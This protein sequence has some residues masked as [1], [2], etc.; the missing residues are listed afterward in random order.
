MNTII[1]IYSK[2]GDVKFSTSINIGAKAKFTLMQEDYIILPFSS[3]TPIDFKL[4]D[5]VDLNEF[6]NGKF[7]GILAKRYEITENQKPTYNSDTGG[8]D[9][10]LKL[11]AYYW[12]WK[13]KIFKYTPEHAASEASWSLT[14]ALDV[15]LGV[16]L[17]NLKA[18]GYTY[19]GEDFT[20]SIDDTVENKAV[21]M[22][23]DNMNLLD[24]LFSMASEENWNCDCWISDN[25][26]HFGRNEYG[27]SVEIRRGVEAESI[28]RSD[29]DGTYATRIY[30]FGST[31]NIPSNYRQ[32][33][34]QAVVNGV[35]QKRLM[36]PA[37]TP[38]IDAYEGMTQEEAIE[39]VVVYDDIY[40]RRVG[41]LS[42]VHTRSEDVENDDGTKE[43]V[44]YYR[45]VDTGLDF[46]EDYILEGEELKITFQ[47]GKLNGLEFGVI[48]NPN[49]KD[50]TRGEQ[51]W[52]IVRNEDYGR[53]LPDDIMKPEDGD[54]YILSGFN[55]QLVSDQYIPAAE[56]ELKERA[57]KDAERAKKDDGT[58]EVKLK[59][60]WVMEDPILRTFEFG[61]KISLIDDT[62]FVN[63]RESRVLGW[64]LNL[65]IP[66]DSPIYTIG[67]S[68][69]YSRITDIED[70]LDALTYK[71]A[72]YTGSGGAG[73]YLIKLN[74]S[75]AP[76][77]SNAFS[78]K[79]S[80]EEFLSK[81]N[82][83]HAKGKITFDSGAEFGEYSEGALGSG[84]A[85]LIDEEGRSYQEV[86]YLTVRRKATYTTIDVQ[87]LKHIGGELILSPAAMTIKSVE[88]T[89]NGY[90]CYFETEDADGKKIYNEF[91]VG[92]QGRCQTF[93][94]E[95]QG[96]QRAGNRYW[97]RLVVETGDDFVVFSKSDADENSDAPIA[98]D[99]VAQLGNR[100]DTERQNA[101][102]YSAYGQ[103]APS[104]K[105]YQGIDSYSL[106]DK[107]IKEE[108]YD[109]S[110]G[111]YKEVTYGDAYFGD[112]EGN[113]YVKYDTAKGV[114]IKGKVQIE[115]GSTGASNLQDLGGYISENVKVGAENL[116]LNTGFTGSYETENLK[117]EDNLESDT[118]LYSKNLE[119]WTGKATVVEDTESVSGYS[120]K[121][122]YLSQDI[123]L[124][125]GEKYVIS[126]KAKN[127]AVKISCGDFE[128][129]QA[130]DGEYKV[131]SNTFT[132]SGEQKFYISGTASVCEIKLERGTIATDWCPSRL[133]KNPVADNFKKYWYLMD[134][135]KGTTEI[136]GGLILTS[137]IRLG[138]WQDGKLQKVNACI[139][140]IYNDDDDVAF[141]AGGDLDRA[142]YTTML[143]KNNPTY[144]PTEEELKNI[145]NCVITHGGRAILN[146]V[147]LR[148]YVYAL[149]G[150]FNGTIYAEGGEFGGY[151]KTS[152]KELSESDAT[153]GSFQVKTSDTETQEIAGHRLASDLN[154]YITSRFGLN[155]IVLP[156]DEEYIGSHVFICNAN[157]PPFHDVV[158]L[159]STTFIW[160]GMYSFGFNGGYQ[161]A[162]EDTNGVYMKPLLGG[163]LEFIG[164]PTDDNGER[165][166]QWVC[167][168]DQTPNSEKEENGYSGEVNFG[169]YDNLTSLYGTFKNGVLVKVEYK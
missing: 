125:N 4:G 104:R 153:F 100:T 31:R 60:S 131:Y 11:D 76:S 2:A 86:D 89:A 102:I 51:L 127:G 71:G 146:D 92:D 33:D 156:N 73:V 137:I 163:I 116:L 140:G 105:M 38:Y 168:S 151:L 40:P 19:H 143:Y 16:F 134:A 129:S 58:Y 24:A 54:E 108:Y 85:I 121:L 161:N 35:V 81:K 17:R 126:Y 145:A 162:T 106:V 139:S 160:S 75:T 149:G 23:Y 48:F 93:N 72:V 114:D 94:L 78:A 21:A 7:G 29:S 66:W 70:K 133:D 91:V 5:Y 101:Q 50:E 84:A 37:D 98:G 12:K 32:V 128:S 159:S 34:E 67:E 136:D 144:I 150:V 147:I 10:E 45:Y 42:D 82:D 118:K 141:S 8:Y 49:P 142:I 167:L 109:V 55:I 18:L 97:W 74:D 112:R 90:K 107:A 63:T 9:Y 41:T 20:F 155:N 26:I 158:G 68:M 44:S 124:I 122:G 130:T 53:M 110:T 22:T 111:R 6:F 52:E 14:A 83:D 103:D 43:T 157:Y 123:D 169:K 30:A 80:L 165:K 59:S 96:E 99:K 117:E 46:N 36:L 65:D 77:E 154:I 13:N 132:F 27:D 138:Q 61:Q 3:D 1:D 115:E 152:L 62:Y 164:V 69:P 39:S 25:I 148:G 79:R 113:N 95:K 135:L 88:E 87:E 119:S 120:V 28:T 64:E 57:Q 166:T 56:Q 15:Q 47:S